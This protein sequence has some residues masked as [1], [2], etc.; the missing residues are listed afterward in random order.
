MTVAEQQITPADVAA[1]ERAREA[2][3]AAEN[4]KYLRDC[5]VTARRYPPDRRVGR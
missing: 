1:Q 2:Q 4:A 3:H 5:I